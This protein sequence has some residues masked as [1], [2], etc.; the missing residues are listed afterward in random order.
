MGAQDEG[1]AAGSVSPHPSPCLSPGTTRPVR[2]QLAMKQ[3]GAEQDQAT[4]DGGEQPR[5]WGAFLW[6]FLRHSRAPTYTC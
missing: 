4:A 3:G 2:T 5:W 6:L 1:A